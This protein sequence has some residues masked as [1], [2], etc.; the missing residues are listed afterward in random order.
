MSNLD[1]DPRHLRDWVEKLPNVTKAR[2]RFGGDE[3]Q[4]HGLEF[5]H[6]H[7]DTYLDIHLSRED[8]ARVLKENKA[9]PHQFAPEA[10]WVTVRIRSEKDLENARECVQS[11]YL[12][13][14][15]IME[16]HLARRGSSN[17]ASQVS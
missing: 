2:H 17:I 8:Q 1:S 16:A 12:R 11:A 13:A 5:M 10:G 7:S 6:F 4:V 9:E 3:F 15:T 14:K